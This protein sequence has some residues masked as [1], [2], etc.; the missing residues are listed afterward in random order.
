MPPFGG[1]LF[2]PDRYGSWHRHGALQKE[3]VAMH[4][5]AARI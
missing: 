3:D 4:H 5:C 2:L 1:W